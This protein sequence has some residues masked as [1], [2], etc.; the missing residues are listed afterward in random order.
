MKGSQKTLRI[1]RGLRFQSQLNFQIDSDTLHAMSSHISD[2]Q[3]L[4]VERVVV[5]LK[6]LSWETMLNKALKSCKT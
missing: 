1:I 4:S 5:E 3:Y 6:S 2:I